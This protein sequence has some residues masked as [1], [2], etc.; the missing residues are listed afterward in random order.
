MRD[1]GRVLKEG[2]VARGLDIGDIARQT[3]I[4]AH[5]LKDMEE[6][7]FNRIPNV[8]DRGYLKIYAN[9]LALDAKPLLALYEQEKSRPRLPVEPA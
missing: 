4:S 3:C 2:R 9:F 7:R 6:G 5:Y 1:I 8:F